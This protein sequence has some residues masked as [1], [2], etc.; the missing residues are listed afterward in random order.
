LNKIL[1][2]VG[3]VDDLRPSKVNFFSSSNDSV[4]SIC[5][6]EFNITFSSKKSSCKGPR[7]TNFF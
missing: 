5:K 1:Q 2:T 7:G 6:I 4:Y 3:R